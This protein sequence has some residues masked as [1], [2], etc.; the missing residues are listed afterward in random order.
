MWTLACSA[1]FLKRAGAPRAFE[2]AKPRLNPTATASMRP[3]GT[4]LFVHVP[5]SARPNIDFPNVGSDP[6]DLVAVW[7]KLLQG[8]NE[9]VLGSIDT[10]VAIMGVDESPSSGHTWQ[11]Q[12]GIEEWFLRIFHLPAG[13]Q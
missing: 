3:I 1:A 10:K 4:H 2:A 8:R 6:D 11:K 13:S 7:S 12:A 9:G 5:G